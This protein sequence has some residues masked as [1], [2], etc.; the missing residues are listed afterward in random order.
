MPVED[1]L[2]RIQKILLRSA[3]FVRDVEKEIPSFR[4]KIAS[5]E[6]ELQT[7]AIQIQILNATLASLQE[8]NRKLRESVKSLEEDKKTSVSRVKD[9]MKKVVEM[10][11]NN[12]TLAKTVENAERAAIDGIF[13][14]EK[15]IFNQIKLLAPELD[16]SSVSAFKKVM[17]GQVVDITY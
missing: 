5:K 12:S 11:K 10:E 7:S 13:D 4:S 3:A 6:K 16:I 8:D 15:N 2:P 1:T 17:D 9:S 14:A